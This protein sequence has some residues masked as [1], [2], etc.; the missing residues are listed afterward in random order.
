MRDQMSCSLYD[1]LS[2]SLGP[3]AS[4]DA[5]NMLPHSF[6]VIHAASVDARAA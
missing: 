6:V 3:Q 1:D 5:G 2:M 4:Q